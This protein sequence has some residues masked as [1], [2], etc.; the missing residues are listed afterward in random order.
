[1]QVRPIVLPQSD[2]PQASTVVRFHAR[3]GQRCTFAL[4]QGF[5]MSDLAHF[6]HYTGGQGGAS[7]PLNQADVGALHIAPL[8][9]REH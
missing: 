7:G 2:G 4:K 1:V 5:N 3:A 9:S 8:P 6:V